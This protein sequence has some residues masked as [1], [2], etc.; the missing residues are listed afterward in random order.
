ME[1]KQPSS[2][3]KFSFGVL[4][5]LGDK[6]SGLA[7]RDGVELATYGVDDTFKTNL[8]TQT[9]ALK[10]CPSDEEY[11]GN[12]KDLTEKKDLSADAVK[13]AIREIMARVINVF[14][15]GSGKWLRF[16]TEGLN[17]MDD[18]N[19]IK[20]GFRVV[21]MSTLFAAQLLP[22]GVTPEMIQNL[23]DL[24]TTYDDDYDA[25]QDAMLERRSATRDRVLLANGLYR[26]I[27]ELFGYGKNYWVTRNS[28]KY[29]D[30]IIYNTPSGN[31][32]LSGKV[33]SIHGTALDSV[34]SQPCSNT[35]ITL[36]FFNET[37]STDA[38]GNIQINNVPIESTQIWVVADEHKTYYATMQINE[39]Q[40]TTLNILLIAGH[41][42][43]LPPG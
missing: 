14:P 24:T 4:A 34:T 40:V 12:V 42:D 35:K 41:D 23:E 15:V 9:Q 2:E 38:D 31:P 33:G 8:A 43:P 37:F 28:A 26:L 5:Q 25:Q 20:C 39:N 21:R 1:E 10:D 13:V 18:P 11:K 30:Y 27:V 36:E 19:L 6:A 16:H 29:K 7:E 32:E 3:F 22:K 17:E